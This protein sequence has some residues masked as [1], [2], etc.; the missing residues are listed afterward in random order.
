MHLMIVVDSGFHSPP[1][2]AN[3]IQNPQGKTVHAR[4]RKV[5]NT[6]FLNLCLSSAL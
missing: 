5:L 3:I 2:F 6:C 1:L 4:Q